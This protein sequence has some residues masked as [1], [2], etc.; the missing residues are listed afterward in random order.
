MTFRQKEFCRL[1]ATGMAAPKAALAAGYAKATA[2]RNVVEIL[3]SPAVE[4][5]LDHRRASA[6]VFVP[7]DLKATCQRLLSLQAGDDGRLALAATKEMR[8]ML[9]AF[10]F[11]MGEGPALPPAGPAEPEQACNKNTAQVAGSQD[12]KNSGAFAEQ[13]RLAEPDPFPCLG[14]ITL[15]EHDDTPTGPEALALLASLQDHYLKREP[16]PSTW[17]RSPD[18]STWSR[19]PDRDPSS[20]AMPAKPVSRPALPAH[21][22][23]PILPEEQE[24]EALEEANK[25]LRHLAQTNSPHYDTHAAAWDARMDRFDRPYP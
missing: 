23:P 17:S 12:D 7:D 13:S 18:R 19:S 3:C 5:Y 16:E 2:E 14:R 9:A 10:P 20:P 21:P 6:A 24:L 22:L 4:A 1:F 25:H 11:L 15:P 8:R